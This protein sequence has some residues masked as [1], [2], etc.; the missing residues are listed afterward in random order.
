MK[1]GNEILKFLGIFFLYFGLSGFLPNLFDNYVSNNNY[2]LYN[3]TQ[4]LANFIIMTIILIIYHKS[5]IEDFCNFKKEN[6]SIG[7]RYWLMGLGIMLI[8]NYLIVILGSGIADNE[9]G[10]RT[11]LTTMLPYALFS[12]VIYAPVTEEIIFRKSLRKAFDNKYIYAIVSG[13]IF[14]FLHSL[15]EVFGGNIIG[16]L[17]I[18][19]Y[20]ALGFS[21]ALSYYKTNNIFTSIIFHAIHNSMAIIIIL[22]SGALL[23]NE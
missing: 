6:L 20:G 23:W 17:Y 3:L 8:I 5:I 1:K 10:N 18:I 4:I 11:L 9:E 16:I 12:M 14:G 7:A 13:L 19:S 21:F 2:L 22:I 15:S